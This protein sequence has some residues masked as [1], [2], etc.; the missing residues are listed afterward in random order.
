MYDT[1]VKIAKANIHDKKLLEIIISQKENSI[2]KY[3]S[4]AGFPDMNIAMELLNISEKENEFQNKKLENSVDKDEL[5]KKYVFPIINISSYELFP[6]SFQSISIDNESL[7]IPISKGSI[8]FKYF[9]KKDL[10]NFFHTFISKTKYYKLKVINLAM[11]LKHKK[12]FYDKYFSQILPLSIFFEDQLL[13]KYINDFFL[14]VEK[15]KKMLHPQLITVYTQTDNKEIFLQTMK[16][17]NKKF[18]VPSNEKNL[19]LPK[20]IV[21]R[22]SSEGIELP[23]DISHIPKDIQELLKEKI[24]NDEDPIQKKNIYVKILL[25]Y[26]WISSKKKKLDINYAKNIFEKNIYGHNEGKILLNEFFYSYNMNKKE[27]IVSIGIQGPP[28]VGK[29]FF[30]NTIKDAVKDS[31]FVSLNLSGQHDGS[32]IKGNNYLYKSASPGIIIQNICK[33]NKDKKSLLIFYFD[34]LDKL[35]TKNGV[36]EIENIMIS[37]TDDSSNIFNDNFFQDIDFPLNNILFIFSYNSKEKI[38]PILLNRF[39]EI[40]LSSFSIKNKIIISKKIIIPELCKSLT[41]P[42]INFSDTVLKK[43]IREKTNEKGIRMLKK[44]LKR[45]I[46]N[47]VMTHSNKFDKISDKTI[48]SIANIFRDEIVESQIDFNKGTIPII[49]TNDVNTNGIMYIQTKR[50]YEADIYTTNIGITFKES[51]TIAKNL[52]K[53]YLLKEKKILPNDSFNFHFNINSSRK[54]D[55]NSASCAIF[56]S[57]ISLYIEGI[58]NHF[59]FGKTIVTG[60]LDIHGNIKNVGDIEE[61]IIVAEDNDYETIIIPYNS[62]SFAENISND[63]KIVRTKN[64]YSLLSFL[65]EKNNK[66]N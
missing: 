58:E 12:E 22:K 21:R 27:K 54:K 33:N 1:L 9:L 19:E 42:I 45:I 28:G 61:K 15:Y 8:S 52:A 55:G 56:L 40:N 11:K 41:I 26:P 38:N 49:Y 62:P 7:I 47:L 23:T 57:I 6:H 3:C 17:M 5:I 14:T 18:T 51:I 35:S 31:T 4:K 24:E 48:L 10:N 50:I 53:E 16:F 39:Y 2:L 59:T 34:E 25:S 30:A 60:A 63:C 43:I 65:K 20:N 36:N 66:K 29:T 46:L 64:I 13:E 37:L 44:I 32:I